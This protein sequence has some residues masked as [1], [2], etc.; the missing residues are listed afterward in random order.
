MALFTA[1]LLIVAIWLYNAWPR[2]Y[3]CQPL[4]VQ[5]RPGQYYMIV[6][7]VPD[8]G[9]AGQQ[10]TVG[11]FVTVTKLFSVKAGAAIAVAAQDGVATTAC[12]ARAQEFMSL[13]QAW[14][15]RFEPDVRRN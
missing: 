7:T 6:Q 11:Q 15:R 2:V 5:L 14:K 8:G 3:Y 1:S 12:I 9:Y 10:F 4:A 13:T